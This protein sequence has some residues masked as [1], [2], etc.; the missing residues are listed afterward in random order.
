MLQIL[1]VS[2]QRYFLIFFEIG[3]VLKLS[4]VLPSLSFRVIPWL[5][6][7]EIFVNDIRIRFEPSGRCAWFYLSDLPIGLNWVIV[8]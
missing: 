6:R 7:S 5:L 8:I 3:T 4:L 1:F 2:S